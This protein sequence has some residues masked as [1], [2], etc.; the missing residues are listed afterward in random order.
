[1]DFSRVLHVLGAVQ[2][3]DAWVAVTGTTAEVPPAAVMHGSLGEIE[4][5]PATFVPVEI[6]H[7][8]ALTGSVGVALDPAEFEGAEGSLP[9]NLLVRLHGAN[10]QFATR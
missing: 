2:G 7:E 3:R 9:G 5:G 6:E 10:V 1:M 8:P 4:R